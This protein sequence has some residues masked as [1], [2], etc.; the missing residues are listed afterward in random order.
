MQLGL[1][2]PNAVQL[3]FRFCEEGNNE[4]VCRRLQELVLCTDRSEKR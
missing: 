2:N 3:R 1:S 4:Q